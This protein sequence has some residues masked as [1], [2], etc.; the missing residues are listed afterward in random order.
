MPLRSGPPTALVGQ[1]G[2][3]SMPMVLAVLGA[4]AACNAPT[5]GPHVKLERIGPD[6]FRYV[7]TASVLHPLNSSEGE[8]TRTVWLDHLL[9]SQSL[10]PHGYN[11][12]AR[13]PPRRAQ[14][15]AVWDQDWAGEVIYIVKCKP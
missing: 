8:H 9:K 12:L 4:L 10:C 6:Q 11:I 2:P 14:T 15:A 3:R 5:S 1:L 7:T 13:T